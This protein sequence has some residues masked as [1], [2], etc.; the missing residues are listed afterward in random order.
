MDAI[1]RTFVGILVPPEVSSLMQ[2]GM[3]LL[4]R[5]PG[6]ENVRWHAPSEYLIQIASLGELSPATIQILRQVLPPIV[7]RF[8][9]MRLEVKGFGGVPNLI[10]PRFAYANLEGDVLWLDQLAQAI[11]MG[12]APY[13]PAREMR[14]FRP[15]ILIGR[16]KTE[17][18]PLRVALGRALKMTQAPDMGV[19]AADSVSL[20]I[21]HADTTGIGY[22]VLDQIPLGAH[23]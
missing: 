4:R 3:L 7:G 21:S 10:Q 14:G 12:V 19:I 1:N 17:S 9:K 6:V 13:V 16:L 11:D 20:M 22:S 2:Q 8:P 15:H 5:K 18:E 23:T